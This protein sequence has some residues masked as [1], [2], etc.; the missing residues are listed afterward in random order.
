[1]QCRGPGILGPAGIHGLGLH[2]PGLRRPLEGVQSCGGIS[3]SVVSMLGSDG[4][5]ACGFCVV[6]PLDGSDEVR[7][8]RLLPPCIRLRASWLNTAL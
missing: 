8:G 1:M 3:V 5:W 4:P 7:R 6:Q 2:G